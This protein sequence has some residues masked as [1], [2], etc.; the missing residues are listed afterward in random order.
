MNNLENIIEAILLVSGKQVA[1]K[2]IAD[3]LG[4]TA[5]E[6]NDAAEILKQK[7][8]GQ[9]GVYL[10]TF[11]KKLQ[12]STN[13]AYANSVYSVLNP[14]REKEL[15]RAVLEV[16]AIIAYRQPVTK[17]EIEYIKGLKSCDYAVQTLLELEMI[18]PVGRK[19]A[20]GRPILYATTDNFLKRFGLEN[21]SDLPDYELLLN[22]IKELSEAEEGEEDGYLFKKDEYKPEEDSENLDK[23]S[24]DKK[25]KIK[26]K[27]ESY[28]EE[29]PDF[30]QGEDIVS[31]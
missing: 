23:L 28:S 20:V 31:I 10:L 17:S 14:I 15:T 12:F 7:Y 27:L 26:E 8:S 9:S 13:P 22:R 11:N 29:L 4:V 6:V 30:L 24:K 3:K 18:E 2:D 19:D 1:V 25:Q 21:L 16:V 5:K